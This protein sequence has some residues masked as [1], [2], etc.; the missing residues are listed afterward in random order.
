MNLIWPSN[1]QQAFWRKIWLPRPPKNL[2]AVCRPNEIHLQA[3]PLG[4][5]ESA[6]DCRLLD[7][8]GWRG[9]GAA[10]RQRNSGNHH[11]AII[12]AEAGTSAEQFGDAVR[13]FAAGKYIIYYRL[14][15]PSAIE[16]LH[17]FHGARDRQKAWLGETKPR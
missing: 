14:R 5:A 7:G 8:P 11:H 12:A 6:R 1:G 3:C 10:D 4:Q 2:L 15:P 17:A 16:V 13:K 9:R